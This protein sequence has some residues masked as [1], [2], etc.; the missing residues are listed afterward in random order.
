MAHDDIALSKIPV[1]Y[2]ATDEQQET[3]RKVVCLNATD[4]HE[5]EVFLAM[6]GLL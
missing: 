3:A 4:A 1:T 6:L 2:T 5:A